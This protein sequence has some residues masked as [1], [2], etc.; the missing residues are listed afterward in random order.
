MIKRNLFFIPVLFS[1]GIMF[2]SCLGQGKNSESISNW[3]AVV[4]TDFTASGTTIGV[5]SAYFAAPSLTDVSLGDCLFLH[6]FTLDYDN[7]PLKEYL[8]ATNIIKDIVPQFPFESSSA[9]EVG[10]HTLPILN[11]GLYPP[12]PYYHGRLF[13]SATCKD[14]N[15]EFKL[16]YN[17][18]EPEQNNIKNLYLIAK[19]SSP[20]PNITNVAT[21]HAFDLKYFIN[22][23]GLD[24][25][26]VNTGVDN[27]MVLRF[28][29]VNIKYLSNIT[30][31]G[32]VEYKNFSSPF[33]IYVFK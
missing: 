25:T 26:F 29:K 30:E 15:P 7:Q 13:V 17:K 31:E 16:I 9:V 10:E 3:P 32:V 27:E 1:F 4:T 12:S 22:Y 11:L 5:M 21:L 20:N 8:T 28:V 2:F 14:K 18:N 24:T 19:P 33:E 23:E 6:Q